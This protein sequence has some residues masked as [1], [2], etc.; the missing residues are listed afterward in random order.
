LREHTKINLYIFVL[1]FAIL[2]I[3]GCASELKLPDR[4]I[5]AHRGASYSHPENTLAAL[6]EAVRLGAHMIEFDVQLTKDIELVV[7]HDSSLDRTT[8]GSGK[9]SELT[10]EEIKRLD[11]GSWKNPKFKDER[12]PTLTEV[13]K[14]MP[15]NVWLN[16]HLKG[17]A[18]LGRKAAETIVKENRINQSFLACDSEA[19]EAARIVDSRILLC[20]MERGDSTEGYIKRTI[21]MNTY[22]IQLR[23][24]RA[25]KQLSR[26][27][28]KLKKHSI[29]INYYGTNSSQELVKLFEAGVDFLLVDKVAEMI[30]AAEDIGIQRL[31]PVF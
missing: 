2:L 4:G 28:K 21:A 14:I 11:A 17:N 8:N 1:T 7:I 22:F 5:C 6:R 3:Q 27:V 26:H 29:R 13:L 30:K 12:I 20:N 23:K 15:K 24:N 9:V 10:L 25:D 16:V 31:I 18:E 19:A